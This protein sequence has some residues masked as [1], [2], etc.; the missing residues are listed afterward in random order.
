[1]KLYT[2]IFKLKSGAVFVRVNKKAMPQGSKYQVQMPELIAGVVGSEGEMVDG[3]GGCTVICLGGSFVGNGMPIPPGSMM[4]DPRGDAGPS[5]G[6]AP[7]NV[8]AACNATAGTVPTASGDATT[9]G[10]T[11]GTA[12]G[13]TPGADGIGA[14]A[15]GGTT[16]ATT[17]TT[18]SSTTTTT[19][20]PVPSGEA[21]SATRQASPSSP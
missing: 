7:D 19:A 9:G 3:P 6:G 18:D 13:E 5:V 21:S 2:S 12:D 8:L 10:C 1:M 15:T 16:T 4:V 14:A 11:G 17:S 20:A